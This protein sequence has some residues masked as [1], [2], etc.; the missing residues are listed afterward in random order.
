MGAPIAPFWRQA[1]TILALFAFALKALVP[2]GY[3]IAPE[4]FTVV[5]CGTMGAKTVTFDTHGDEAPAPHDTAQQDAHCVFAALS[6]PALAAESAAIAAPRARY[7][8]SAAPP[9]YVRPAAPP[10]GPPLPARGP[11]TTA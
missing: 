3:M 9:F 4:R 11:P 2:A 10:T 6:A 5:L 1:G 8:A 7:A